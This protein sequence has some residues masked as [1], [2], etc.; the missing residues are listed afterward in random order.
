MISVMKAI[1]EADV[2]LVDVRA[3]N[4]IVIRG[5]S[6]VVAVDFAH[7]DYG[8]HNDEYRRLGVNIVGQA[9]LDSFRA[10]KDLV[11]EWVNKN[12]PEDVRGYYKRHEGN[13]D[14]VPV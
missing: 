6:L 3:Q 5:T 14:I 7:A 8:Y 10:Y 2:D 4:F 1:V 9:F 13:K 12:M 11:F